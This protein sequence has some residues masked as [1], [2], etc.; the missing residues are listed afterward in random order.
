MMQMIDKSNQQ[1]QPTTNVQQQ[2]QQ[3]TTTQ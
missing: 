3:T 1:I 2:Q